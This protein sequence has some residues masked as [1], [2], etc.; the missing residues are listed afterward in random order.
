[1]KTKAFTVLLLICCL[2]CNNDREDYTEGMKMKPDSQMVFDKAKWRTK[3]G[4][5]YPYRAKML[6]DVVY[7]DT[8]RRLNK[9]EILD[10]LGEP[11]YYRNNKNFLYYTIK[12]KRLGSWPL[13]TKSMVIKLSEDNTIEWIKIHE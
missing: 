5:D 8:I 6:N 13:H 1:M 2:S 11:S 9:V 12:Q 10:L 4:A 3:D 7:N